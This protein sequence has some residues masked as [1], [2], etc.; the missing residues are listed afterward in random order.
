MSDPRQLPPDVTDPNY[1]PLSG[2]I[3]NLTE[4]QYEALVQFKKELQDEGVFV[5]ERMDDA[6]LLRFLRARQFDVP[7][8]KAMLVNAEKWRREFG[9]DELVK[10]FDFKEQAQVDKYYPQY[11]HKMDKDGRPLYVQQLGKLDVKALYA[12]TTPERMLQ[13]LVCEYEKYLTERLPACSKA[14]GHPVETTCTIMDLQNVSLS[15]FYRVKDYVNAASTIGQNYYPECMGKFFIINA[16]WGFSTVWGFIKPWLDPVTVSKIDILGSGY[17]DRLLAQ[18]PAEN[19]PKEFGGRCHLPRSGPLVSET[20][21]YTARAED[22]LENPNANLGYRD[23]DP[24]STLHPAAPRVGVNPDGNETFASHDGGDPLDAD[25]DADDV[26]RAGGVDT[27]NFAPVGADSTEYE[28]Y[29]RETHPEDD[30][31]RFGEELDDELGG[32]GV[33]LSGEEPAVVADYDE[34]VDTTQTDA[35]LEL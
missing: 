34:P 31:E 9:V 33:G 23:P 14:V 25:L 2:R 30:D 8:A 13:R 27:D 1:K 15:S 18:V 3:G 4:A 19:L 11:Y 21:T 35:I 12:I 24:S 6:T 29:S 16:P 7:N 20:P 26:H 5:P 17:K 32:T 10:T 28:E 22:D